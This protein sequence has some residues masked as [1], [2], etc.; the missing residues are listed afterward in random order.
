[1]EDPF[2]H[3]PNSRRHLVSGWC[4]PGTVVTT[5]HAFYP[6][7]LCYDRIRFAIEEQEA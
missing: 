1:M 5:L 2:L 7:G 3:S 6:L 4:V